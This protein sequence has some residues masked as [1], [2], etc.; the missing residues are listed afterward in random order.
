MINKAKIVPYRDKSRDGE[1]EKLLQVSA[2]TTRIE[3]YIFRAVCRK[4]FIWHHHYLVEMLNV[5]GRDNNKGAK[6][7][8]VEAAISW[9]QSD[10]S[11]IFFFCIERRTWKC[12]EMRPQNRKE[13]VQCLWSLYSWKAAIV[14]SSMG[15]LYRVAHC[16][17][18]RR[19]LGWDG[20]G[21]HKGCSV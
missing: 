11:V 15:K 3:V 5:L 9:K 7:L 13:I 17:Q 21:E 19:R 2:T 16:A 12:V 8:R 14:K 20:T 6:E 10:R 1:A 18:T 4:Y